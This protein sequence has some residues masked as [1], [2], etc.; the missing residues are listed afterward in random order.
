MCEQDSMA[1]VH[2]SIQDLEG[3]VS[4]LEQIVENISHSTS[5][6]IETRAPVG[7]SPRFHSHGKYL[8]GNGYLSFKTSKSTEDN[9]A[10]SSARSQDSMEK[11]VESTSEDLDEFNFGHQMPAVEAVRRPNVLG[12]SPLQKG[13][14]SRD[15]VELEHLG[16]RRACD[17]TASVP[18]GEGPSARSVWQAS[19]DEAIAAIRGA[20]IPSR[21]S[22]VHRKHSGRDFIADQK[23][24][25]VVGGPF[26]MLWSRAME[27]VR[28]GDLNGAYVEI[29]GSN[30]EL[31]LVRLMGRT[32]P[33]LDQLSTTTVSQLMG[34]IKQFLQQQSFLDCIILGSSR[35]HVP[36]SISSLILSSTFSFYNT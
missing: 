24:N 25:R 4:R 12:A 1:R 33:V 11:M 8:S 28:S 14:S 19:K 10:P 32:G 16:T 20:A 15:D 3:R 30:D 7:E 23:P 2:E 17:R 36:I 13:I 5:G 6:N 35:Y 34:S 22:H 31:L 29:L 18:Q 9:A 21:P 27:S 26:W